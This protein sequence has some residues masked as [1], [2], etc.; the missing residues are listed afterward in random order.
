[1]YSAILVLYRPKY[2][3]EC[4]TVVSVDFFCII[5]EERSFVNDIIDI[6]RA[7]NSNF[8]ERFYSMGETWNLAHQNGTMAA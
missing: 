1:M 8:G 2:I 3:Y 6:Y 7:F 4:V 5:K